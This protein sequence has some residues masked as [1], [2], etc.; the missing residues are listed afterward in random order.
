MSPGSRSEG[1]ESSGSRSERSRAGLPGWAYSASWLISASC[2]PVAREHRTH[3][4]APIPQR[5]PADF[6]VEV[7]G[8]IR[9][10]VRR[11]LLTARDRLVALAEFR[12]LPARR[13]MTT[14]F[15]DR[16]FA[17]PAT[18]RISDGR[19]RPSGDL[20]ACRRATHA[21]RQGT[22]NTD[23]T[24][25]CAD[26]TMDTQPGQRVLGTGRRAVSIWWRTTLVR[27]GC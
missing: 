6:D 18:H 25:H 5:V 17:L 27:S 7:V 2:H 4:T 19:P 22:L 13:W 3:L 10:A 11:S 26:A 9:Q 16:A 23:V 1:S 12:L 15:L 20:F 24:A 21:P 8:L 14:L